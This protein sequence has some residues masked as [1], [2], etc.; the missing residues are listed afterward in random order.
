MK[1]VSPHNYF[2]T[3]VNKEIVKQNLSNRRSNGVNGRKKK[4]SPHVNDA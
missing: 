4:K 3:S 2:E 1:R